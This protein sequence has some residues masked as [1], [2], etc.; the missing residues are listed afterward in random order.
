MVDGVIVPKSWLRR[1]GTAGD[2][3]NTPEKGLQLR[4]AELYNDPHLLELERTLSSFKAQEEQALMARTGR[5]E[6]TEKSD[7][8]ANRVY[9]DSL[10]R[11][12]SHGE[13]ARRGASRVDWRLQ[14]NIPVNP[15]MMAL[16]Q[17]SSP[18][19][20]MS[21]S[22][23][24]PSLDT[25]RPLKKEFHRSMERLMQD[26]NL[27]NQPELVDAT[28]GLR[29]SHLDR[30]HT[31]F[32]AHDPKRSTAPPPPKQSAKVQATERRNPCYIEFAKNEPVHCGSLRTEPHER[33]YA[34]LPWVRPSQRPAWMDQ[35]MAAEVEKRKQK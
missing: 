6:G 35:G 11:S 2:D 20:G 24:A 21:A 28:P 16:F 5:T 17:K 32:D 9:R 10:H 22:S 25:T 14:N 3:P 31:W 26:M 23:S 1:L 34:P 8:L 33:S 27:V 19:G 12:V 4:N 15:E 18:S 13:L 29:C 7:K 30:M